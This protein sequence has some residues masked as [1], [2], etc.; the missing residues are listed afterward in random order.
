[1]CERNLPRQSP[2]P[3]PLL[4]LLL[5]LLR[6]AGS[7]APTHPTQKLAQKHQLAA[8]ENVGSQQQHC[9]AVSAEQRS[10]CM[11]IIFYLVILYGIIRGSVCWGLGG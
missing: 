3:P 5:L 7:R 9:T 8:S 10:S 11:H 2:P 4:L 1:M 6:V